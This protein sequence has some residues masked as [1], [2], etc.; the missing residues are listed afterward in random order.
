MHSVV[1]H[2]RNFVH[3]VTF[4]NTLS[5]VTH[6][7]KMSDPSTL[8]HD[9]IYGWPLVVIQH[10]DRMTYNDTTEHVTRRGWWWLSAPLLKVSMSRHRH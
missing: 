3:A 4:L 5:P 2:E 6:C 10:M 9:F 7:H 8:V 1:V